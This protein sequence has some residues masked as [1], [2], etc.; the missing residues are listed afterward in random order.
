[1]HERASDADVRCELALASP[2]IDY[3]SSKILVIDD[4]QAMLKLVEVIAAENGY[5]VV[6][7]ASGAT[8]LRLALETD[9]DLILLDLVLPD[10]SG[11]EVCRRLRTAGLKVT[12]LMI[13]CLHDPRTW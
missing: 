13:S 6:T 3:T 10:M 5:E 7:A 8:G 2:R 11:V 4:D 1:M 9:P 12:V